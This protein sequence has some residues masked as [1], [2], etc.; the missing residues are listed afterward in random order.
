MSNAKTEW[1]ELQVTMPQAIRDSIHACHRVLG[2]KASGWAREI[3]LERLPE[4][5]KRA[6][7]RE[8]SIKALFTQGNTTGFAPAANRRKTGNAA[9]AKKRTAGQGRKAKA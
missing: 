8:A 2:S 1:V 7:R 6:E 5:V 9:R 4:L 3:L